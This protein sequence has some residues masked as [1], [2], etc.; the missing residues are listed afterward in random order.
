MLGLPLISHYLSATVLNNTDRIMIERISG[1]SASG[2]YS[3]AYSVSMIMTL[4]N[5]A[6]SQTINPWIYKKFK[7][8]KQKKLQVFHMPV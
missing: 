8:I 6:L 2:I 1:E 4:F 7:I 3:F 5:T